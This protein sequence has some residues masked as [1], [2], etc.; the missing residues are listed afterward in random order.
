[1]KKQAKELAFPNSGLIHQSGMTL[2]DY[3]ASMA[4]SGLAGNSSR[5]SSYDTA[6]QQA[7]EIADLMLEEREKEV[8]VDEQ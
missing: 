6:V 8:E 4:I 7:Y 3:F 5:Y 1:M 2:R